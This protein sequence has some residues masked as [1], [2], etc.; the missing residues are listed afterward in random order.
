MSVASFKRKIG[1]EPF[2]G[3]DKLNYF[4]IQAMARPDSA[5]LAP[6]S[7]DAE[8]KAV[9]TL[10]AQKDHDRTIKRGRT[11]LEALVKRLAGGDISE[12][13]F[14]EEY[15][16]VLLRLHEDLYRI[17][18]RH[19]GGTPDAVEAKRVAQQVVDFE[20]QWIAG[21]VADVMGDVYRDDAGDFMPDHG[22]LQNRLRWYATK[23]SGTASQAWVGTCEPEEEFDWILGGAENHCQDCPYLATNSPYTKDTL[24]TEPRGFDTPCGGSCDC[25]LTRRSDGLAG[26]GPVNW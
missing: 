10:T 15:S 12:D 7:Y 22:G 21:L 9:N 11:R 4:Q 13:V 6:K 8:T 20:Q 18:V 25:R 16:K 17:G 19:A 2:P 1:E 24:Y 14:K 5:P 26:F 23:A 3:D